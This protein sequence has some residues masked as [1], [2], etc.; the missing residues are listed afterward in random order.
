MKCKHII[1]WIQFLQTLSNF[2]SYCY[3]SHD[4][5]SLE[6]EAAQIFTDFNKFVC[7]FIFINNFLIQAWNLFSYNCLFKLKISFAINCLITVLH[8]LIIYFNVIALCSNLL[9]KWKIIS[10]WNLFLFEIYIVLINN[11][12]QIYLLENVFVSNEWMST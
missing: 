4:L 9:K 3:H 5:K 10:K 6:L 11:D 12:L 2:N 8:F 1:L 7:F